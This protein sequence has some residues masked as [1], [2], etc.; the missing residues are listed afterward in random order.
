[1]TPQQLSFLVI[2]AASFLLLLSERL[3]TDVVGVLIIVS[4]YCSGVLDSAQALSGFSS[5]PAI[6][7]AAVFV[8]GGAFHE[9]G[10]SRFIGAA[11]G[12]F[13]GQ[14]ASRILAVIMP[15]VALMSAF[16]HHV[17]TTAVMMPITLDLAHK[18]NVPASKLLM[19]LA[20]SA[21]LGTTATIIGAPAFLI[22][23]EVLK[24]AGRPGLQIFS[25]APIGITL[26]VVCMLYMITVGRWLLPSLHAGEQVGT[27]FRLDRYFTELTVVAESPFLHRSISEVE[28]NSRYTFE[29]VGWMR[30]KQAQPRPYKDQRLQA[31]DVLLIRTTPEE[32]VSMSAEPGVALQPVAKYGSTAARAPSLAEEENLLVQAVVAP[33]ADLLGR[34]VGELAFKERFGAIVVGLWRREGWLQERLAAIKLRAGDVLVLQSNPTALRRIAAD[35]SF[36]MLMPLE[37][38]RRIRGKAGRTA[39][40]MLGTI[41]LAATKSM[42]VEMASLAGA[43]L[44]VLT[45]CISVRQ[46]YRS[47][48]SRIYVFIA[49]AIPLGVAMQWT[50]TAD[51]G[52]STLQS[53]LS[54][55]S[56]TA[57]LSLLF[58]VVAIATQFMSDAATTAIFAPVAVAVANRLGHPPEPYAVTVGMAAVAAFLTPIG[59]HGNLLVYGP[60]RYRFLDF[61]KVGTPMTLIICAVVVTMAPWMWPCIE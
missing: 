30:G 42:R 41:T 56:Q 13:A 33:D 48:D 52:A 55:L 8:L 19:P 11:V 51:L 3:R 47:I 6:T 22:A 49:G 44:V 32:I 7:L 24:Q 39:L 35:S 14:S 45:G 1:M 43:L 31:G 37:G 2:L 34:S 59:H 28:A 61:V 21:S 18:R 53:H 29:V 58:W 16:T 40:I 4:L 46:A 15:A 57:V 60:G 54:G 12:R 25:I 38:E 36:L 10:V 17:T 23:D 9:A 26:V 20:F 27:R 5:E 50:G